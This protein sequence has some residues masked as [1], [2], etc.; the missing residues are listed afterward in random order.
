MNIIS[1][2]V[3]SVCLLEMRFVYTDSLDAVMDSLVYM[4]NGAILTLAY[5]GSVSKKFK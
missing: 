5:F 3:L 1:L 2:I 4:L